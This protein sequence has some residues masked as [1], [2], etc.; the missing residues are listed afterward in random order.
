MKKLQLTL[1]LLLV[2]FTSYAT[3][4]YVADPGVFTS[5]TTNFNSAVSSSSDYDTVRLPAL[6]R[7]LDGTVTITKK[8]C[9]LGSGIDTT[10]LYRDES[11]SDATLA[12]WG[13]MVTFNINSNRNSKIFIWRITFKGQIPEV[14]SG[15]GGSLALDLGLKIINAVD[16]IIHDCKFQYFGDSGLQIRHRDDLA[17]G[18]IAR[19]TFY[20]NSKSPTGLGF[21]Y[22][23]TIYGEDLR[24]PN[25]VQLGSKNFIFVEDCQFDYDRHSE[26]SAKCAQFV[27]RY[28][29]IGH[30]FVPHSHGVDTHQNHPGGSNE[31]GTRACE[32][33]GN[34]IVN[35]TLIDGVTPLS[36]GMCEDDMQE[37]AIGCTNG[38]MVVYSNVINGYRF[39]VGVLQDENIVV[40][41]PR[42]GQIGWESY[43]RG[44]G[45]DKVAGAGDL[46]YW[47]NTF[48]NWTTTCGG[49]T[50]AYRNYDLV[51]NSG[52]GRYIVDGK[53]THNIAKPGYTGYPYPHPDRLKIK[54]IN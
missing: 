16:F 46:F 49:S 18:L 5:I 28:N 43:S 47:G 44:T 53:E 39:G 33:Y 37:R 21:G 6:S 9:L 35:T 29:N 41:S 19:C 48:T 3:T 8:I 52:T 34:T 12:G 50:A 54:W 45:T 40:A 15:D 4:W 36:N 1:I 14:T 32:I 23:L 22:G 7:R 42:I 25:S 38:D 51:I 2:A 27:F 20:K 11:I 24:W 30:H 31:H 26:A 13:P 10:I 17:R